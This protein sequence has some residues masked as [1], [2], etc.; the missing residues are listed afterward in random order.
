MQAESQDDN[1]ELQIAP[2][3]DPVDRL[4]QGADGGDTTLRSGRFGF[5]WLSDEKR[6]DAVSDVTPDQTS[7][8][9]NA[10]VGRA[11]QPAAEL[12]VAGGRQVGAEGH[13][14]EHCHAGWRLADQRRPRES[15]LQDPGVPTRRDLGSAGC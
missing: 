14:S 2:L 15:A 13:R 6:T 4:A 9:D 10:M 8:V 12:E 5:G 1:L 3:G 7:G 11:D